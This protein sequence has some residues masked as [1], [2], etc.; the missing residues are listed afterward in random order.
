MMCFVFSFSPKKST[1]KL[2]QSDINH[3]SKLTLHII[4]TLAVCSSQ[5]I[6]L[7]NIV[8]IRKGFYRN[9]SALTQI[10]ALIISADT[11]TISTSNRAIKTMFLTTA[12]LGVTILLAV[13]ADDFQ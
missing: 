6:F 12:A 8:V 11:P 5:C 3:K 7:H 4:T 1:C 10:D 9:R 2:L 13:A